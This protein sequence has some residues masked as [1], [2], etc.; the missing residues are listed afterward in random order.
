M[1]GPV[2]SSHFTWVTLKMSNSRSLRLTDFE[3]LCLI[4]KPSLD[5]MLLHVLNINRKVHKW[6]DIDAWRDMKSPIALSHFDLN[7]L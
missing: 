1:I 7:K 3:A 2:G 6:T 4:E 5:R